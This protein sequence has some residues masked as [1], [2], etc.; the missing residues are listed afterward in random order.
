MPHPSGFSG[1]R[2]SG[3]F[4]STTCIERTNDANLLIMTNDNTDI[5]ERIERLEERYEKHRQWAETGQNTANMEK[6]ARA[7]SSA[8]ESARNQLIEAHRGAI[9]E[10]REKMDGDPPDRYDVDETGTPQP[11]LPPVGKDARL[12]RKA[13]RHETEIEELREEAEAE[14]VAQ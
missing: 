4:D 2:A 1:R 10:C 11:S 12:N 14:E 6:S 13:N 3:P 9:E 8:A 5:D 7:W